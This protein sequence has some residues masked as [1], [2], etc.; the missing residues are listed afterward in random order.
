MDELRSQ[1]KFAGTVVDADV[2]TEK[3]V[4]RVRIILV[5]YSVREQDI[6]DTTTKNSYHGKAWPPNTPG[7]REAEGDIQQLTPT[8]ENNNSRIG[9]TN[10]K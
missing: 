2:N 10:A 5:Q 3:T 6:D 9:R 4:I 8:P 1:L 7:T